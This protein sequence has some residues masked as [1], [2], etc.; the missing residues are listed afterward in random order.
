MN[1]STK[2][3]VQYIDR[4]LRASVGAILIVVVLMF[5]SVAPW[6]AIIAAYP[7]FTAVLGHDLLFSGVAIAFA[8]WN[9]P[10]R[11]APDFIAPS[12]A[13]RPAM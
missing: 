2:T 10:E 1:E 3:S 12:T 6:V 11:K 9:G 5:D 8:L 7:I 13:A 4:V